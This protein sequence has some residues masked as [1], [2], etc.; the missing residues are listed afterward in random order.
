MA[1]KDVLKDRIEP[2]IEEG[3]MKKSSR[4]KRKHECLFCSSTFAFIA[5][6]TEHREQE[7]GEEAG[8]EEVQS[9]K[10]LDSKND[11][12]L[13]EKMDSFTSTSKQLKNAT[14]PE[15]S[16]S[17]KSRKF[18]PAMGLKLS[19]EDAWKLATS[20][21]KKRDEEGGKIRKKDPVEEKEGKHRRNELTSTPEVPKKELTGEATPLNELKKKLKITNSLETPIKSRKSKKLR[22]LRKALK[23]KHIDRSRTPN[24]E[25]AGVEQ[26]PGTGTTCPLC[27]KEFPKNGPMRRH[28]ED[29]HQ[30][31]EYPCPGDECGKVRF[32]SLFLLFLII[33]IWL[34]LVNY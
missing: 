9:K 22:K 4:E 2:R 32:R 6:L 8:V 27:S 16:P 3:E 30:P 15:D 10:I 14:S 21:K 34:S 5:D 1:I 11:Q 17:P 13:M 28:F 25:L 20:G 18:G 31:G 12:D 23:A 33:L 7:H 29:I 26:D 19:K 24:K